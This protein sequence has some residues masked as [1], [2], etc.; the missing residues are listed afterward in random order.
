[1]FYD[2]TVAYIGIW[3]H[4]G[5]GLMRR[6]SALQRLLEYPSILL[7]AIVMDDKPIED[8]SWNDIGCEAMRTHQMQLKR[9]MGSGSASA[10]GA[11][12]SALA[13]GAAYTTVA[14]QENNTH[15]SAGTAKCKSI[16]NVLTGD[17]GKINKFN[18]HCQV[19]WWVKWVIFQLLVS[20]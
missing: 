3:V 16:H 12:P 19:G 11:L 10:S 6:V 17:Q 9:Q 15:M 13:A 4:G 7:V 5:E 20:H 8:E 18:L 1:M 2:T 14:F